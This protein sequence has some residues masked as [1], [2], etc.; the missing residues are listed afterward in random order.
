MD[1]GKYD[2]LKQW[3]CEGDP[4]HVLGLLRR[5]ESRV[6]VEGQDIRYHTTQLMLF[7]ESVNL[8]NGMPD[9]IEV[10]GTVEGLMLT[11][12]KWTCTCCGKV[13]TWHPGEEALLWIKMMN[14][15]RK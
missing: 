6:I 2:G 7:K 9:E 8:K 3:R 11:S 14:G 4:S 15:K 5:V 1:R 10:V 13:K 12:M